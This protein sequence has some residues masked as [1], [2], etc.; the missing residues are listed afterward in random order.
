MI[1]LFFPEQNAE[2]AR[3]EETDKEEEKGI[4]DKESFIKKDMMPDKKAEL[5]NPGFQRERESVCVI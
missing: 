4:A 2:R 1:P 3:A 5:E